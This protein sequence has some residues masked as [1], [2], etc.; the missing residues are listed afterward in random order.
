MTFGRKFVFFTYFWILNN[1]YYFKFA[2]IFLSHGKLV[3]SQPVS[4]PAS[5]LYVPKWLAGPA[6]SFGKMAGW[7]CGPFKFACLISKVAGQL[8]QEI[9]NP[10]N[11]SLHL[12]SNSINIVSSSWLAEEKRNKREKGQFFLTRLHPA[13]LVVVYG[14]ELLI[15]F[16][17]YRPRWYNLKWKPH[18]VLIKSPFFSIKSD[19]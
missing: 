16:Y 11:D 12:L 3:C 13:F 2:A 8:V 7:A 10:S 1:Y 18:W 17:L 6:K 14:C 19:L 4:Q 9:S 5:R 15:F